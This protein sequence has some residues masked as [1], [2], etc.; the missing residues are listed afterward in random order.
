VPAT[1]LDLSMRGFYLTA[2]AF[3]SDS[4]GGGRRG[5]GNGDYN[6]CGAG[7]RRCVDSVYGTYDHHVDEIFRHQQYLPSLHLLSE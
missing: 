6:G 1:T 7:G 3:S 4:G 5:G 2:A